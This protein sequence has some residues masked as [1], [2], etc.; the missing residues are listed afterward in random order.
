MQGMDKML[1]SAIDYVPPAEI[2]HL[3]NSVPIR[4]HDAITRHHCNLTALSAAL[5]EAG[6][7]TMMA[8]EYVDAARD[9]FQND[10]VS[11]MNKMKDA[12]FERR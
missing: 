6:V 11:A 10:L 12:P 2:L 8:A 9:S 5:K 3:C 4:F 1:N 7:T